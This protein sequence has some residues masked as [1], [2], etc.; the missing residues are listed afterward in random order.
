MSQALD[1]DFAATAPD[2]K[3]AAGISDIWTTEGWL[4]LAIVPDFFSRRI[5]GWAVSDR[6]KKDLAFSALQRALVFA[7]QRRAFC[8]I[9]IA[10]AR[11]A[12]MITCE[13]PGRHGFIISMSGKGN[14][15][16]NAMVETLFKTIKSERIWRTS[17]QSRFQAKNAIARYT[18]G[19]YNPMRR[20][21]APG[22]K[23]PINFEHGTKQGSMALH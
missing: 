7:G 11:I 8:I 16:D 6:L 20:H 21:P 1:Q 17:F 10:A 14:C 23:S 15:Y 13:I 2:Q 19:F 3:W 5:I 4:Y 9:L 12:P 22:Y 18:S